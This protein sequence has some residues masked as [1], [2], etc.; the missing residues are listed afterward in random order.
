M[1]FHDKAVT[2]KLLLRIQI[3]AVHPT[4]EPEPSDPNLKDPWALQAQIFRTQTI[5]I[6]PPSTLQ[7]TWPLPTF[8]GDTPNV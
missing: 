8:K 2:K 6:L 1:Y 7:N 3:N 5:N 4:P